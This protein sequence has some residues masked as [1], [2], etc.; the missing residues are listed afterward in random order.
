MTTLGA[1][2]QQLSGLPAATVGQHLR[3]ISAVGATFGAILLAYSGLPSGT[4]AEH[5]LTNP[6]TAGPMREVM[7]LYSPVASQINLSSPI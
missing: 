2:L 6:I 5:L 3:A 4:V 7:R 1:R